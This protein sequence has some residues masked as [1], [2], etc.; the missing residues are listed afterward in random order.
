MGIAVT[1][2]KVAMKIALIVSIALVAPFVLLIYFS[3]RL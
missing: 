1:G 3:T 2:K